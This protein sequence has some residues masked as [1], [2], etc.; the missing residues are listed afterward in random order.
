VEGEFLAVVGE[1][2]AGF[3][4]GVAVGDA[5]EGLFHG[6]DG[7]AILEGAKDSTGWVCTG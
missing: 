7:G 3:L 2:G 5:V 4:D 6:R 1:P